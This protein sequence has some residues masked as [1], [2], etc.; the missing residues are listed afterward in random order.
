M[1]ARDTQLLWKE[2]CTIS[3]EQWFSTRDN[4]VPYWTLSRQY[5][6]TFLVVTAVGKGVSSYWHLVGR[7]PRMLL[8][9]LKCTGHLLTIKNYQVQNVKMKKSG[10]PVLKLKIGFCTLCIETLRKIMV[11]QFG[12][13]RQH[14]PHLDAFLWAIYWDPVFPENEKA[15][16]QVQALPIK[17]NNPE[18]LSVCDEWG[19]CVDPYTNPD[20]RFKAQDLRF[21]TLYHAV[22]C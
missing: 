2:Y 10:I 1:N 16:Q 4:F 11:G 22:L 14:T 17:S 18:D 7:D 21:F 3:V 15:L 5:L 13:W 19:C 20:K 9:M 8:N 12:F 6:E